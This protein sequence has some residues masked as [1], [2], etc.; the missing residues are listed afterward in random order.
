MN[1]FR[2]LHTIVIL[3]FLMLVAQSATVKGQDG[4]VVDQVIAV[5]GNNEILMSDIE[6]QYLQILAQ[7]VPME[8]DVKCGILE[9]LL[10]QKLILNQA[11]IDSIEVSPIQVEM[12][13]NERLNYY[14]SQIGSEEELETYFNKSIV[15][16]K[17]D[18]R[19]DLRD[20][21]ITQ[22]MRSE[23]IG[24]VKITPSEIKK[25]HRSVPKDSLP[26]VEG[27][28]EYYQIVKYPPFSEDAI[29][30]MREKLLSFR[31]RILNG[32]RFAKLAAL[33][34]EGPSAP[35]GGDIGFMSRSELDPA[36]AKAAFALQEGA[37]SKIVESSFGYHIIQL[38][39]RR[40]DRVHT[41]HILMKP[42]VSMEQA[43]EARQQLDSLVMF[44]RNDSLTF[45]QAARMKSDDKETRM[46]GGQVVNPMTGNTLF[47]ISNLPQTDY[48]VLKNLKEGEISEPFESVDKNGKIIFKV[49]MLKRQIEP[50]IANLEYDYPLLTNLAKAQKQ[51]DI[52]FK[53]VEEKQKNTYIRL[54]GSYKNCNF[55]VK[56][57]IK[58]I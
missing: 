58:D 19:D 41:R 43:M 48:L 44:I 31:E 38:V 26:L 56:G 6:N 18:L 36:Y 4:I 49:V 53:W 40:G 8:G 42:K 45:E 17:D 23:I 33:Y 16:I 11:Q 32:E 29:L 34:S 15:Q 55:R 5:V 35:K 9:E 2:T 46:N 3:A 21:L 7:R 25:F 13:L 20:Q 14:I 50:H 52:L 12:Q 54:N 37:V 1:K 27:Q 47:E 39:E 24:D 10:L 22:Q 57:W 28:L 30:E 51:E